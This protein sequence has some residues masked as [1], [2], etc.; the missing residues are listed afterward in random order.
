MDDEK[1][2]DASRSLA[3][4][5]E[6]EAV[7]QMRVE[8]ATELDA[9]KERGYDFDHTT[10]DIFMLRV[11][12]GNEHDVPR[13]VCWYR[14]CLEVRTR[15]GLNEIGA[16]IRGLPYDVTLLPLYKEISPHLKTLGNEA[17]LRTVTGDLVYC[18]FV[19][20]VNYDALRNTLGLSTLHKYHCYGHEARLMALDRLSRETG[21]LVKA[22][23]IVHYQDITFPPKEII[24]FDTKLKTGVFEKTGPEIIHKIMMLSFPSWLQGL[25][26]VVRPLIPSKTRQ[27]IMVLGRNFLEDKDALAE[28]GA[29][30]LA[31]VV[32]ERSM[33]GYGDSSDE[34]VAGG[35]SA[36]GPRVL[37]AGSAMQKG[38]PVKAGQVVAWNFQVGDTQELRAAGGRGRLGGLADMFTDATDVMFDVGALW[39]VEPAESAEGEEA[40]AEALVEGMICTLVPPRPVAASAGEVSGSLTAERNGTLLLRWSNFHGVF[41][42][43]LLKE[44]RINAGMVGADSGQR[45]AG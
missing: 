39:D 25:Y 44:F 34:G 8:L 42:A 12:R 28:A 19:G 30:L 14:E 5:E 4:P 1:Q 6:Q 16:E 29:S 18:E 43:K 13:A 38:V 10:G 20:G 32:K 21:R 23:V 9:L 45:A 24:D 35:N 31:T 22:L 11:L 41:R 40:S 33:S 27:N 36:G 37:H 2:S 3:N 17:T 7:H 26:R 15:E